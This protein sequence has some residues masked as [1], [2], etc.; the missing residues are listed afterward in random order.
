[1]KD[2][3]SRIMTQKQREISKAFEKERIVKIIPAKKEIIENQNNKLRVAAYCRKY[4]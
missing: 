1:M 4:F 3:K 2:K